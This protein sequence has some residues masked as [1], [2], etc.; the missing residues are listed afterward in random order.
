VAGSI[1]G[2]SFQE[3]RSELRVHVEGQLTLNG[4]FQILYVTLEEFGLAYV[5]E[6]IAQRHIAKGRLKRVLAK[7]C[8]AFS[9]Y[10]LY[11]Q[12]DCQRTPAVALLA[13]VRIIVGRV[14]LKIRVSQGTKSVFGSK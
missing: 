14:Q 13:E 4:T 9:S 7:W 5:P 1:P 6:N 2:N 11:P 12:P 8:R 10:H 3:Y